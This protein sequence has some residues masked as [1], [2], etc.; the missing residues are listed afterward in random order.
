MTIYVLK[1]LFLFVP[2]MLVVMTVSF[3]MI[4][5]VPG[6]PFDAERE[7]PEQ[8][9]ENLNKKYGLDKPLG[10]QYLRYLLNIIRFDFGM[11]LKY[12]DMSVNSI[13]VQ[14]LP[15]SAFLGIS[16]LLI[17]VFAGT[18]SGVISAVNKNSIIDYLSMFAA[19]AGVSLPNFVIGS[20]LLLIFSFQLRIFPVAG[21][22]SFSHLV[23]P[24][25]TLSAVF[26][27]YIARMVRGSMLEVLSADYI[28]TARAKGVPENGIVFRHALRTAFLPVLGYLGPAAAA[29]LTGSV[30]VEKIFSIPGMGAHFV[31][32][33]LNR[34]YT[35]VMGT[36]LVYTFFLIVFN[37]IMDVFRVWFDPRLEYGK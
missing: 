26:T 29:V 31:N 19:M 32:A 23:L 24:A 30:V 28:K 1:R 35:L 14:A 15:V 16:A 7:V 25:I 34:D 37:L 3:F 12:R 21:W 18:L 10:F 6:G 22:G 4:R 9:K 5:S 2:T 27:A 33:A 36:V 11:S 20:L 17:A 8:V 13:M